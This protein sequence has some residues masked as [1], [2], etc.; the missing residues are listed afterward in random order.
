M[1]RLEPFLFGVKTAAAIAH[2]GSTIRH[3]VN[4]AKGI[5]AVLKGHGLAFFAAEPLGPVFNHRIFDLLEQNW[6]GLDRQTVGQ[7]V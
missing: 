3:R 2:H 6:R 5:N 1:G 4:K 7:G